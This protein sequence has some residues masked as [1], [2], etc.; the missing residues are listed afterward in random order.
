MNIITDSSFIDI[1]RWIS[2]LIQ[3]WK[4][5][6]R[7]DRLHH[8]TIFECDL[9]TWKNMMTISRAIIAFDSLE[10]I[11][12]WEF[13]FPWILTLSGS[14]LSGFQRTPNSKNTTWPHTLM[15][16]TGGNLLDTFLYIPSIWTSLVNIT[17][18]L[19]STINVYEQL[20]KQYS[21]R[22]ESS[23]V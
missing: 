23:A 12:L 10:D 18:A 9:D 16:V 17:N 4:K 20:V 13:S 1:H 11:I 19:D 2:S 8:S 22:S 3:W 21:P 6:R 5:P 7:Y 15:S 14:L